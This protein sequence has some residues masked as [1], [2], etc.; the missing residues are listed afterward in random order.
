M[1]SRFSAASNLFFKN[2]EIQAFGDSSAMVWPKVVTSLRCGL[3]L[4]D[5][6]HIVGTRLTQ[7]SLL[8]WR[9]V[10]TKFGKQ[11]CLRPSNVRGTI[12]IVWVDSAK[13]RDVPPVTVNVERATHQSSMTIGQAHYNSIFS[14]NE[15]FS[16]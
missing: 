1:N 2:R 4:C 7:F 16:A 9:T 3:I 12:L 6:A 8:E 11:Y 10:R 15:R 13:I 14:K 5:F